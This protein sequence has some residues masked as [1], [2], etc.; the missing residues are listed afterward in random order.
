MKWR[1][2]FTWWIIFCILYQIVKITLNISNGEKTDN[3]SIRLY[4][5]KIEKVFTFKTKTGY[6]IEPLISETMKLL[7]STESKT[8][9]DKKWWKC[10]S[11]RN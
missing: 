3:P 5:N 1:V 11:F 8:T 9:K 2:W 4:V 6:Y 7:G 10:T